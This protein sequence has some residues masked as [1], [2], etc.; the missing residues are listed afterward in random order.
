MFSELPKL[1]DRDFAIGFL[2]PGALLAGAIWLVLSA[3]G[4][5]ENM[6]SPE[7]LTASAV[8][9]AIMFVVSVGLLACNYAILRFFEGYPW[10]RFVKSRERYW[11]RRFRTEAKPILRLQAQSVDAMKKK[12]RPPSVDISKLFLAIEN[13][14]DEEEW[15]MP[16]KFGNLFRAFEVYSRI[17]YGIENV[18]IWFR[19]QAV[20]PEQFR[21][22]LNEAWS[23][24][25]FFVNV[26]VAGA[27]VAFCYILLMIW[28][29]R[30][31]SAWLLMAA[32]AISI[33]SDPTL[34]SGR[35]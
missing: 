28:A 19:L 34:G 26:T 16:T 11:K 12:I 20:L 1:F 21:R 13:Y 33:A 6:P 30:T 14:P 35:G 31:P 25:N 2:L 5:T 15:V 18:N 9:I 23:I 22:Q 7:A 27:A 10:G 24:L 32:I 17:M 8:G 3:F 29:R 4:L